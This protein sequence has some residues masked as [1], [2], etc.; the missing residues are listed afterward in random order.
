MYDNTAK[1]IEE[2]VEAPTKRV[3]KPKLDAEGQ[4]IV[5]L[6]KEP[7]LWPQYNEDGSPL[8]DEAGE[9]VL[10]TTRMAKPKVAKLYPQY[11][12]DGSPLLDEAGEPVLGTTRMAKPKVQ[13]LDEDGNPIARARVVPSDVEAVLVVN[14]AKIAGYKG[15]RADNAKMLEDGMTLG[16]FLEAGGDKGFLR[17]YM[18]DGAVSI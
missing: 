5:K 3:R 2:A 7:K 10:G 18:R 14:A 9:P 13:R 1:N 6:A 8:L 17:F 11:A 15:A 16:A 12:E 4:P